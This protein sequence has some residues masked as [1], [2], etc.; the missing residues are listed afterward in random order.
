MYRTGDVVRWNADGDLEFAG[1]SDDQIK[2][3]GFRVEPGEIEAVLTAHPQVAHAA[4]TARDESA[5]DKRLTAY[6]VLAGSTGTQAGV[7]ADGHGDLLGLLRD[8]VAQRLPDYMVPAVVV[9]LGS[10]PLTVNGKLD[11]KALPAPDYSAAAHGREP[12]TRQEEILCEA[13]ADVL[14]LPSIGVDD[15]FFDLGGHSLLAIQLVGRIRAVLGA[16]LPVRALFDAPT[17]AGLASQLAGQQEA[18]RPVLRPRAEREE[19]S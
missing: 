3:R 8:Y 13:F 1:R 7:A 14:G 4:V 10:L 11:R 9:V 19:I 18:T 17:V 16:E 5:A 12:S 6:V 2:L 15:S